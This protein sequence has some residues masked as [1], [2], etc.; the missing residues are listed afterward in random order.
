MR[1][2]HFSNKDFKVLKPDFLGEN[3]FTKNDAIYPIKRFFCY[4]TSKPEEN[5]F[6]FSNYRYVIRI[7]D[8]YIY[9]LDNDILGL[10]KRF[11]NDIDKILN[12]IVKKYHA[13]E[14]TTSFKTYAI[15]KIYKIFIKENLIAGKP[16]N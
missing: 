4:S 11:N 13:I 2:Y 7:K 3:P 1:L 16:W 14:Y 6:L 9:N 5:C 10:K 15:F 12:F 8:K